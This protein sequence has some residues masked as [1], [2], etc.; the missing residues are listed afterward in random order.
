MLANQA[1]GEEGEEYR[2]IRVHL[3]LMGRGTGQGAFI[4]LT[5]VN[6]EEEVPMVPFQTW[7]SKASSMQKPRPFPI[8]PTDR[9]Q[10]KGG[11]NS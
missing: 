3:G 9:R 10:A 11:C 7:L 1:E 6:S 8:K 4:L 2:S 5:V